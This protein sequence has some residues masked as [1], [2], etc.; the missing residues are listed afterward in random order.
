[1][2]SLLGHGD[3][4]LAGGDV[5]KVYLGLLPGVTDVLTALQSVIKIE[6]AMVMNH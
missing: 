6:N 5:E 3:D 2:L 1:M 4:P